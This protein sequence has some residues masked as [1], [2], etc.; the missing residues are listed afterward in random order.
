MAMQEA[1]TD[2]GSVDQGDHT[3]GLARRLA[4][5]RGDE[6][7]KEALAGLSAEDQAWILGKTAL[8]FYP[9][10]TRP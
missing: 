5:A 9:A 7:S 2:E 6:P 1:F 10:L 8:S 4:V 3:A